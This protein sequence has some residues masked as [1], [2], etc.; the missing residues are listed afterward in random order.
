M[1]VPSNLD[2]RP[3]V[4]AQLTTLQLALHLANQLLLRRQNIWRQTGAS[5]FT[6]HLFW[7][8]VPAHILLV[9]EVFK[10]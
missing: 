3:H 4:A 8:L 10:G 2:T 9:L 5:V 7:F 1:D 6:I